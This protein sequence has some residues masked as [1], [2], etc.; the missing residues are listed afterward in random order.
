M[1][2]QIREEDYASL[3]GK[4]EGLDLSP[5]ERMLLNAIIENAN[6]DEV[7]GFS[8]GGLGLDNA[9]WL[10]NQNITAPRVQVAARWDVGTIIPKQ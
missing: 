2:D 4:L 10:M 1:S 9:T 3:A 8:A 6:D 7:S 5:S